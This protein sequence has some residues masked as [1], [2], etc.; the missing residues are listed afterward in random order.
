MTCR[1]EVFV[2]SGHTLELLLQDGEDRVFT[3]A[4]R[5]AWASPEATEFK[6]LALGDNAVILA[7]EVVGYRLH[8]AEETG[9]APM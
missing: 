2:R 5:E 1:I 8:G 7:S 4:L 9:R 6:P 3:E